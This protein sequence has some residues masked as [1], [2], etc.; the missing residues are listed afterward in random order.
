MPRTV[1][2]TSLAFI[3][4]AAFVMLEEARADYPYVPPTTAF[5][6]DTP[7]L[8]ARGSTGLGGTWSRDGIIGGDGSTGPTFP[9]LC[10]QAMHAIDAD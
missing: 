8:A 9:F 10:K 1:A 4:L 2:K 7:P 6:E 3:F 5:C